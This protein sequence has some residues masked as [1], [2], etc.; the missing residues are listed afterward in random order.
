MEKSIVKYVS[1]L[2]W[3]YS[4]ILVLQ[5]FCDYLF[6]WNNIP[7]FWK[8]GKISL[9]IFSVGESKK[10]NWPDPPVKW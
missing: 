5:I 9:T 6:G 7:N 8:L 3:K 10:K 1:L 2:M 4:K